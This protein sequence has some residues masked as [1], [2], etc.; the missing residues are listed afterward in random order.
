MDFGVS[1]SLCGKRRGKC[2]TVPFL[3]PSAV[4]IYTGHMLGPMD[5]P[6]LPP[7]PPKGNGYFSRFKLE[8]H[9]AGPCLR[10][11]V[12]HHTSSLTSVEP[13]TSGN[14]LLDC[15]PRVHFMI[16]MISIHTNTE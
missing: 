1:V 9:S 8:I 13:A 12:G 7:L 15:D 5:H 16:T 14:M 4:L 2:E 6:R 11:T 3:G 10:D